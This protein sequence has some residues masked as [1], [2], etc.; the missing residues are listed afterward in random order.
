MINLSINNCPNTDYIGKITFYKDLIYIGSNLSADLYIPD[1]DIITN[2]IFIEIIDNKLIAHSH[3]KVNNFWVNGKR[4]KNFKFLTVGDKIKIG[5]T[6]IE[7]IL[8]ASVEVKDKRMQLNEN[9]D[10]L[11]NQKQ[12]LIPLVKSLQ[13]KI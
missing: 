2:H 3:K 11:I 10:I 7:I 13:E 8:F 4:T 6:E 9:T 5:N 1:K 12:E